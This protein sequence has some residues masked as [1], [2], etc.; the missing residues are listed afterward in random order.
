[1]NRIARAAALSL[2]AAVALS[3]CVRY[4]VDITLTSDDTASGTVVTAV[5]S[6]IAEQ[7]GA[8]SDEAALEELFA[9]SPFDESRDFSVEDY[10]E[11][12]YIGKQYSFDSL[13]LSQ[14]DA[15]ADMFT[16]ERVGD[17]FVVSSESTPTPAEELDQVPAGAESALSITFP[18]KVTD[19]NGTLEGN[20]VTWNLF[21]QTEPLSA[22]ASATSGSDF[23]VWLVLAAV[24]I[25]L[26]LIGVVVLVV[27]RKRRG[28]APTPVPGDQ[29]ASGEFA[30]QAQPEQDSATPVAPPAPPAPPEDKEE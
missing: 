10:T 16:I 22:T 8:E 23:P 26:V 17:E 4:N 18:G 14:L 30:P 15:F 6:G 24:L 2:I 20:T 12:D 9:D 25:L 27:V 11:D 5:Q 21:S 1:M 28:S 7:L 19:H 13:E 3:G 29:A